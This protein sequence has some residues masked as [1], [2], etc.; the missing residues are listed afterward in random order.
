MS[1]LGP[2][3]Q[4]THTKPVMLISGIAL[5]LLVIAQQTLTIN[6]DTRLDIALNNSAHAPWFFVITCLLWYVSGM[7]RWMSPKPRLTALIVVAAGLAVGLEALQLLNRRDADLGDI[8]RNLLGACSALCLLAGVSFWRQHKRGLAATS[9]VLS[10]LLMSINFISVGRVLAFYFQR[11]SAAPVLVSFQNQNLSAR[12]MVRGNW[13]LL[14]ASEVLSGSGSHSIARVWLGNQQRWPGLILR[15]P[16][17]DWSSYQWL[18]IDA[19]S[20]APNPLQLEVRLETYS[21]RGMASTVLIDL[22][23]KPAPV[24]ISLQQLAGDRTGSLQRVKNVY[25]IADR[26]AHPTYFYLSSIFLE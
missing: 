12:M 4:L 26:P 15:E 11:D 5:G 23:S 24:R 3:T 8:G 19:F 6:G 13:E 16:L 14:P 25:V 21:D 17:T 10:A 2:P 1:N 7:F 20:T 9:L 22:P 18:Y